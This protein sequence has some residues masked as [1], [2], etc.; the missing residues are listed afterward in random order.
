MKSANRQF[1]L[2]FL[3]ISLV[4]VGLLIFGIVNYKTKSNYIE[5]QGYVVSVYTRHGDNGVEYRPSAVKYFV[6]GE[7][8]ETSV[9]TWFN[10]PITA[11]DTMTV[12]YKK[13]DPR[14]AV[15]SNVNKDTVS[16]AFMGIGGILIVAGVA[17]NCKYLYDVNRHK[18]V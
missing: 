10:Y 3:L 7:A 6:D 11:G 15:V 14:H 16:F 13:N 18:E 2:G 12:R 17:F 4:G 1:I 9:F 5:T 8:Y